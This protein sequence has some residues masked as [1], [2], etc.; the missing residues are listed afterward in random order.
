M[1][2]KSF[3]IRTGVALSLM[4]LNKG[5]NLAQ[6][7]PKPLKPLSQ[8]ARWSWIKEPWTAS[9]KPFISIRQRVDKAIAQGKSP[10]E[11]AGKYKA[12][13]LKQPSSA[14]RQFAWGYSAWR[15][16]RKNSEGNTKR[17]QVIIGLPEYLAR[18]PATHSAEFARMHFLVL[19]VAQAGAPADR[20]LREVGNRLI[21]RFP[22]DTTIKVYQSRV[23]VYTS[24]MTPE[25]K[26]EAL[27]LAQGAVNSQPKVLNNYAT[28]GGVYYVSWMKSHSQSDSQKAIAAYR[29][30][31][32]LAPKDDNFRPRAESIIK[33]LQTG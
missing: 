32:E 16:Y 1:F 33:Q 3:L 18:V 20:R 10:F 31:L 11:L 2:H 22:S 26:K 6:A 14:Q 21:Q 15:A 19:G 13:A 27:K 4:L 8:T 23:I 24:Q 7:A 30:Y 25:D 12:N 17:Q 29:K 5:Q 28:L 9:D